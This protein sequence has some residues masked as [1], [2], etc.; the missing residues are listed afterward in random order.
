METPWAAV[1]SIIAGSS[2]NKLPLQTTLPIKGSRKE[3]ELMANLRY[4]HEY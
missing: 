2:C 1:S 4:L 3:D